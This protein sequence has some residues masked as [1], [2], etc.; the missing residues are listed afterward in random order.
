MKYAL[1]T[2]GMKHYRRYGLGSITLV[3][4]HYFKM[5]TYSSLV[6]CFYVELNYKSFPRALKR[7]HT[8]IFSFKRPIRTEVVTYRFVAAFWSLYMQRCHYF[9]KLRNDQRLIQKRTAKMGTLISQK[10][11]TFSTSQNE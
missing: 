9:D 2:W 3:R 8:I 7:V 1:P 11:S 4:G 6:Y 5:K 10:K